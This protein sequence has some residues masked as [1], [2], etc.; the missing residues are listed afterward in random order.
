MK[1]LIC[2]DDGIESGGIKALAEKFSERHEVL[3]V[4]PNGNRSCCSHT[5]T[6]NSPI[7]ICEIKQD[8]YKAYAISGYPV[9]C[10]KVG[11][12]FIKNFVPDVVVAGINKAHNLGTDVM[13]S[14][15]VAIALEASYFGVPAF[16]FSSYSHEE[17]DFGNFA[18]IAIKIV[19]IFTAISHGAQVWNVN[20]PRENQPI[21]GIR[22]CKLGKYVYDDKYVRTEGGYVLKSSEAIPDT[23]D[24]DTDVWL[25]NE[26]YVTVTPLKA[27]AT[28][29]KTL[30]DTITKN[31]GTEIRI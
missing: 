29:E 10:V 26:G 13:Y 21:L 17:I 4:A 15:T 14:G 23:E 19:E 28:D 12:H 8:K 11:F 6:L 7:T 22:L 5:L 25:V 31:F 3:V 2:N 1:I 27:D 9:D 16:S 30:C 20:F 24:R 18:E